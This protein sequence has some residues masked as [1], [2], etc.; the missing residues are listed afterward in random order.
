LVSPEAELPTG[1]PKRE[2]AAEGRCNL[3]VAIVHHWLVTQGG[4]ERVLEALALMFP[5]ADIFTLMADP[6]SVPASLK[7]RRITESYLARIPW[8]NRFH[9][10]LLPLYPTA[11]EQLDL[12]GYDLVVTSDAGPMKG[13]IV[14]PG[15]VHIC[16]CHAPMRYIWNQFQDY[17]NELSGLAKLAFSASAHY[18]RA[19]DF[20]AAQR[21]SL[22]VANSV[23]VSDRIR[24][25]YSRPSLVLYPPVDT[26]FARLE[27]SVDDSYLAVGRL[28]A[29]KRLDLLIAACNRLGRRLR[30]IGIGPEE[31]NL[32]A[33][34]G[35]SIEFL[36][37]VDNEVLWSEYARCRA[38]LFAAEEDFGMVPVEA[39]ACGRP[40]IAYGKGGA[41][42]SIASG[43]EAA[44]QGRATGVFFHEQ[45][46]AA[47]CDAMVEFESREQDFDPVVISDWAKR[48]D[49]AY[50][51][52]NFR[53]LVHVA[54]SSRE[55]HST[56]TEPWGPT[57]HRQSLP[58]SIVRQGAAK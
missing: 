52:D 39:Q 6:G 14:E 28:V 45:T 20:A 4:G 3:R 9:R 50:F 41:L 23:N 47:V 49:S 13:V 40:V 35:P 36:G 43:R 37:R 19:W 33:L 12:R 21:V 8:S 10:H 2:A 53:E 57:G 25:Y 22:F 46:V 29:Y 5:E 44:L 34:A 26:S 58:I 17:R 32:R 18:V 55:R 42:E 51:V 31:R 27:T 11:V 54:M 38:L 48:F 15:A 56:V 24:Q 30:I 16:Y 7:D 1:V